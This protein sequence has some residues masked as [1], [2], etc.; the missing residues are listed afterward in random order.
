MNKLH[1]ELPKYPSQLL[2][3][4]LDDIAKIKKDERY[5]INTGEWHRPNKKTCS[6]CLGGA[7]LANTLKF[8]IN[9]KAVKY[10]R[11]IKDDIGVD[12]C[13]KLGFIDKFRRL[14]LANFYDEYRNFLRKK[15]LTDKEMEMIRDVRWKI[16][17]KLDKII[18]NN[19][20]YEYIFCFKS[21]KLSHK[22]YSSIVED[23]EYLDK[24]ILGKS[25]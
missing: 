17:E 10:I 2:K 7:V 6:V 11:E 25:N 22:F 5:E 9:N 3:L 14:D 21:F 19:V 23:I 16:C 8:D 12:N 18:P 20:A 4:A 1:A 13:I 24:K 15:H